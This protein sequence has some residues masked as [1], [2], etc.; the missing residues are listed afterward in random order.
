MYH[1][2]MKKSHYEAG[3]EWGR[4]LFRHGKLI[5]DQPTFVVDE[6]RKLFAKQCLPLYERHYPEILAEIKGVADG[7]CGSYE[8]FYTFLFSMY[9]FRLN[10]TVRVLRIMNKGKRC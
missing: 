7:Q 5:M 4:R 10:S 3:Y 9:C 1:E 6:K 2:R 8:D